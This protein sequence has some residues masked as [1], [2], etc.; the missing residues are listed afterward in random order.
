MHHLTICAGA[1]ARTVGWRDPGYIHSSFL[2][3]L[4]PNRMY[5]YKVGH[6]L[7][8]NTYIWSGEYQ[9]IASTF[10]GQKSLQR[11]VIF[12]DMGKDE[13]D[14]SNEYDNFQPDSLNTT[15]QLIKDLK[16]I[17]IIFHVGD[18]CYVNG[19][20]RSLKVSDDVSKSPMTE[21]WP[22]IGLVG[23]FFGPVKGMA[24]GESPNYG[25]DSP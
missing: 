23:V 1:P 11:V 17:D 18:I 12:E 4:W 3:D 5:T 14:G 13:A 9:F 10:P 8:N 22:F 20:L 25:G 24:L 19:I 21:R 7:F 2:K 16:K 15:K 6:R